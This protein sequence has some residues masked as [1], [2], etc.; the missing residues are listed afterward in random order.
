MYTKEDIEGRVK[1]IVE[2]MNKK[3]QQAEQLQQSVL[4]DRGKLEEL[5]NFY[6][7]IVESE[8]K[9]KEEEHTT[10]EAAE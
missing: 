3:S 5:Q 7:M 6:N 4:V 2:L 8:N 10:E 1:E 9:A